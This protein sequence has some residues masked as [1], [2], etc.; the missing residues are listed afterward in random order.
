MHVFS[1]E[2]SVPELPLTLWNTHHH[3]SGET[4][5]ITA[6]AKTNPGEESKNSARPTSRWMPG[7]NTIA[8]GGDYNPEQWPREVWDEDVRLMLEAGVN[9]VSVGI[10]SWALLEPREG[11]FDFGWLD[12]VIEK[13]HA[14]GIGVSL[15]TPTASPPAWFWKAY[16]DARP[17]NR[18]GVPL[19]FG[20]RG[21]AS[22]SSPEYHRAVTR[23]V[24]ELATRY[25][26]HPAVRIWHVH[27]E[28]GAPISDDYSQNS[29]LAFRAWLEDRYSSLDALNAAWGTAFWGQHYGDWS[30]ID[31]P[32][33]TPSVVN[34]AQQLDFARFSNDALLGCFLIEKRILHELSPG[35]PVTT[36]YMAT[37]CPSIDYWKWSREMDI[38]SNDHYLT[39][40]REDA[41]VMLAMD[42]DVTR[43]LAGGKPWL[44]LEHSTSAVN[45]QE[46]NIAKTPGQLARNSMAHFARGADGIMFFQWRASRSGAE[47]FHSAIVPHAG[48]DSRI[49]RESKA[50]GN[51]L[52][53]LSSTL[54]STVRA[55][56][57]ILWDWE[58]N[59][60]LNLEWRP[61]EDLSQRRQTETFYT[62]LWRDGITTDFAH[63]ESDLSG[64]DLV[65][66]P[67]LYLVSEAASANLDAYVRDGG[68]FVASY[69]SGIVGVN[70]A[71]PAGAHPGGLRDVL[72]LQIDEFR[73]LRAGQSVT[74]SNG[75][76]G[77]IW[78]DDI[79]PAT[80]SVV[81]TYEDG[82]SAGG[83]AI[84]RNE[85]G[86]GTAWYLSTEFDV[87]ALSDVLDSAFAEAGIVID[88]TNDENVETVVRHGDGATF[89]TYINHGENDVT[90]P[91]DGIDLL[92]GLSAN[93]LVLAAGS[94]SVVRRPE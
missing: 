52:G 55:K 35:V 43:S 24:T 63:P 13:L 81:A 77:S 57:A 86:K 6:S 30:E 49:F 28:Y 60:A 61:S 42:A 79:R 5:S 9:L 18:T 23:I 87:A 27:N 69:F 80:A 8:F 3:V 22:P 10:F 58:S 12:D 56:V 21:M 51:G 48:P 16:P 89:T 93:P 37:S 17:V 94:V 44:L 65:I 38:I 66:A 47:K 11:E 84:T 90:I 29:V 76:S 53:A 54:G 78:T 73:P 59:W 72:G 46:R 88:P 82:P 14:A 71:V 15:G 32:R 50:L 83:A 34:P 70:D 40:S 36:N 31:V 45:W 19:G 62:R 75:L 74:L 67:T 68:V 33:L 20:S 25:G 41:H 39:A 92:T 85:H 64:Y 26:N 2:T 91:G 4:M 1:D 7:V